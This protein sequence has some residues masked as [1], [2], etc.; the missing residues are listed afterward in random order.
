MRA[1]SE[2][3]SIHPKRVASNRGNAYLNPLG[4]LSTPEGAEYKILPS[5]DCNNSGEKK[6]ETEP[7]HTSPG[8]R[9]Q[10]GFRFKGGITGRYPRLEGEDYGPGR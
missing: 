9:I 7:P 3:A 2:T 4:V 5:F 6:P 1:R 8:C 10:R